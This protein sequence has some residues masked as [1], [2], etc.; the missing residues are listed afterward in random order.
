MGLFSMLESFF[1]VTLGISCILLMMLIYHFKQR[2]NK[3]ENN[4]RMMFDVINN[5][6]QELS[7]LK[8]TI[9]HNTQSNPPTAIPS[10]FNY[11]EEEYTKLDVS[12]NEKDGEEYESESESAE[13]DSDEE[14]DCD[15]EASVYSEDNDLAD[16]IKTVAV[17]LEDGIDDTVIDSDELPNEELV[18]KIDEIVSGVE[19]NI[20]ETNMIQVNKLEE[21]SNLEESS[22]DTQ[23]IDKKSVYKKMTVTSLKALVI[24]K[25][26]NTDPS[27]LKKTE[28]LQI[29]ENN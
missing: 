20:D 9:H 26:L 23:S 10:Q 28:L 17:E 14:T 13:W 5:M 2:I 8:N 19:L 7:I 16:T 29:L 11:P 4:N 18:D 15:T 6:V 22:V 25:G 3:L 21:S 24:E 1:F 27:K 12:L